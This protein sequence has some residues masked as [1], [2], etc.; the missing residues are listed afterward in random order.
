MPEL[1]DAAGGLADQCRREVL[2]DHR[3]DGHFTARASGVTPAVESVLVGGD[4]DQDK[5]PQWDLHRVG[6]DDV[7]VG[8]Q[9]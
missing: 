2:F 9:R 3:R 8:D 7:D 5:I 6:D 4:T 1:F